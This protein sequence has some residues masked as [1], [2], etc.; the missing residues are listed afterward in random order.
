MHGNPGVFRVDLTL[1]TFFAKIW[2]RRKSASKC[3]QPFGVPVLGSCKVAALG[4][5]M[6]GS[7]VMIGTQ[8]KPPYFSLNKDK[9][10]K[11]ICLGRTREAAA[12]ACLAND[13]RLFEIIEEMTLVNME[14]LKNDSL[15]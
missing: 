5:I 13:Q 4:P 8:G 10:T 12:K 6:R 15:G 11:L 1:R 3:R 2:P 7:V 9:R 14:L